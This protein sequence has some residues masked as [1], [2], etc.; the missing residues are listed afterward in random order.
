[1][2]ADHAHCL[3]IRPSLNTQ[4][5]KRQLVVYLHGGGTVIGSGFNSPLAL[6]LAVGFDAIV[7]SVDYR[8]SPEYKY[9]FALDDCIQAVDWMF[10]HGAGLGGD[11]SGLMVA[12][13][14]A[15]GLLTAATAQKWKDQDRLPKIHSLYLMVPMLSPVMTPHSTLVF[16]VL[17]N[18]MTDVICC[19]HD[20]KLSDVDHDDVFGYR[21]IDV[22]CAHGVHGP[23]GEGP[24]M[25]PQST[26]D[27]LVAMWS[28]LML[29]FMMYLDNILY[30]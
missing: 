17:F 19:S 12:G 6:A 8:L 26:F 28:Y 23:K 13:E 18:L 29:T 10:K 24:V 20:V 22:I 1:M 25:T 14:S 21:L 15:G 2:C 3:L 30:L 27:C 5:T 9:P 4:N 11:V 7:L 16:V